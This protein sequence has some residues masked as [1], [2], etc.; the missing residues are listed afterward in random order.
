MSTLQTA[1]KYTVMVLRHVGRLNG[2]VIAD[3]SYCT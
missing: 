1:I 3:L 2:D